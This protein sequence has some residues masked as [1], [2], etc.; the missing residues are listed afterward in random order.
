MKILHIFRTK[1]IK[2]EIMSQTHVFEMPK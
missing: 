2:L 1:I